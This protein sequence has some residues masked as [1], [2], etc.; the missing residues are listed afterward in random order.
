MSCNRDGPV[1]EWTIN[2][3][4]KME[5]NKQIVTYEAFIGNSPIK[6]PFIVID[7]RHSRY[8]KLWSQIDEMIHFLL[9][10][11]MRIWQVETTLANTNLYHRSYAYL[12]K[13]LPKTTKFMTRTIFFVHLRSVLCLE[14]YTCNYV[15]IY[16][17]LL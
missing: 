12:E 13:C 5:C 7:D 10:S 11:L 9:N 8:V 2:F 3:H 16:F 14:N 1:A 4:L 6:F 15:S 17:Y